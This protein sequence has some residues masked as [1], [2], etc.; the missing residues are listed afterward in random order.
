[1][2]KVFVS[3][4]PH[5]QYAREMKN[6]VNITGLSDEIGFSVRQLRGFVAQKKIPYYKFGHKTLRFDPQKVERALA[7]FEVAA[8]GG[9]K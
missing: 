5:G 4:C 2:E 7:K 6:L 9:A 8:I 1:M 3:F